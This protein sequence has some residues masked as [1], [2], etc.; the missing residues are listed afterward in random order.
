MNKVSV[1]VSKWQGAV[2]LVLTERAELKRVLP[3]LWNWKQLMVRLRRLN[4][5]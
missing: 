1:V 4:I 5:V 2:L 3:R